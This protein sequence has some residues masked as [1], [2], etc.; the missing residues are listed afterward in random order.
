MYTYPAQ[1]EGD[2]E[3]PRG[4]VR[5]NEA[6]SVLAPSPEHSPALAPEPDVVKVAS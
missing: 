3:M 6:A 2:A 4:I 5:S 1:G